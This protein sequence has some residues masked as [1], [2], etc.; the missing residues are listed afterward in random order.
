MKIECLFRKVPSF[1]AKKNVAVI[2]LFFMAKEE[3]KKI[4]LSIIVTRTVYAG[5]KVLAD[6]SKHSI[7]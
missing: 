5:K 4:V 6:L 2:L 7:R 1:L 3:T